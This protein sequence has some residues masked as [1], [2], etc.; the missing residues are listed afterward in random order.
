[1]A[2]ESF[3]NL[4]HINRLINPDTTAQPGLPFPQPDPADLIE[5]PRIRLRYGSAAT[6]IWVSQR[7]WRRTDGLPEHEHHYQNRWREIE[8]WR[9]SDN[10]IGKRVWVM[11][12]ADLYGVVEEDEDGHLLVTDEDDGVTVW[13]QPEDVSV[14]QDDVHLNPFEK[15]IKEHAGR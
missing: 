15:T 14:Q 11:R 13:V 6:Q 9:D 8:D 7:K 1:M 12:H 2:I 10:L 4:S 5:G 3:V